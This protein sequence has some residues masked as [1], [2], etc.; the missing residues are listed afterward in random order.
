MAGGEERHP[1]HVIPVQV[2]EQD[3]PLE[4]FGSQNGREL[5]QAGTGI[6][7][8]GGRLTVVGQGNTRG[9]QAVPGELASRSRG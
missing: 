2:T 7:H 9:V 3:R 4:G 6:E 5:S 1:V 8:Q